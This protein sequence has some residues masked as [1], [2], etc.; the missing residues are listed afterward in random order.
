[1]EETT[2]RVNLAALLYNFYQTMR[3][4]QIRS[5]DSASHSLPYCLLLKMDKARQ[6]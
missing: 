3:D 5:I 6:N 4:K 2:R 1:M